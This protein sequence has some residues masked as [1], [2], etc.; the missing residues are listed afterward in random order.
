MDRE[1]SITFPAADLASQAL[2]QAAKALGELDL[3]GGKTG[4]G[5]GLEA[6]AEGGGGRA[7]VRGAG[8]GVD[9]PLRV[10]VSSDM[11][12]AIIG[13]GGATIAKQVETIAK[14]VAII[15]K[16]VATITKEVATI[17]KEVNTITMGGPKIT[18][19]F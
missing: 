5:Q 3:N 6:P 16:V 18:K 4:A 2:G 17:T 15:T 9:F 13:R 8:R 14:Q 19:L 1:E 10:L 12:G 7:R 11:V